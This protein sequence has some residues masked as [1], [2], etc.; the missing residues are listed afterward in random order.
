[1]KLIEFIKNKK[2][3]VLLLILTFL[4]III[5]IDSVNSLLTTIGVVLLLLNAFVNLFMIPLLKAV[6]LTS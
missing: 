2:V 3:L 1:M 4:V 5:G 6:N